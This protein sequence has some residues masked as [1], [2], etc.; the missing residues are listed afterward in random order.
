MRTEGLPD[1][2]AL[3]AWFT[4]GMQRFFAE[5]GRRMIGWDE[6][7]A[8]KVDSSTTIMWWRPWE[9]QSVSLATRQGCDV[10]L[11]PQAWFY[12]SL[13]EDAGSLLRTCNFEML[14]DSLSEAQKRHIKGVQGH[15]WIEK[16]PTWSRA[17]YMFY[18]KLLI[19]AEKAWCKPENV[20]EE[21]VMPRLLRYCERLGAEGI[22][23]RISSMTDFH[24]F[25]VFIDSLRTTIQCPLPTTVLRYTTD[26]T[27]PPLS[28]PLYPESMTVR[29]NSMLCIRAFH[30]DGRT[31]DWVT[32]RYEKC[33]FAAPIAEQATEPG[34]EAEW[35]FK[36]FPNCDAIAGSHADGACRVDTIHFPQQAQGRRA[37]GIVYRG[38]IKVPEDRIYTFALA[39]NDE[40]LLRIGDRVV[41]D[42]DGEHSLIEKTGQAALSAGLHP[43]ELR[44]FRL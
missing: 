19:L 24:E 21:S 39:S 36:R 33:D 8:D 37:V 28:S 7:L 23:N 9:P 4:R 34:L 43:L 12:F 16:I 42:N 6:L 11:C 35:F 44:F 13:E 5:H 41:I 20:C 15:L 3:Q 31:G 22:N 40:S 30:S 2:H 14:P 32:I 1:G 26:G 17:E 38:Y 29:N 25:C 27:V 10:I 18:P